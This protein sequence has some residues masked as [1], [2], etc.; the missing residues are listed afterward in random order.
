MLTFASAVLFIFAT[1]SVWEA[2][3][4]VKQNHPPPTFRM[5]AH[6]MPQRARG[7]GG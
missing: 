4:S 2:V 7:S 6:S 5:Q 1:S 3:I